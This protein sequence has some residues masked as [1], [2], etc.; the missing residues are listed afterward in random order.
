MRMHLSTNN[1]T[2]WTTITNNLLATRGILNYSN[3][4]PNIFAG[5]FGNGVFLSN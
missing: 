1:G 5:T 2:N 3:R 4:G